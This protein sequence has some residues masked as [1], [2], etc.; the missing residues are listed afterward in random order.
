MKKCLPERPAPQGWL[1]AVLPSF[2]TCAR[3]RV[4]AFKK[5]MTLWLAG[6]CERP[7]AVVIPGRWLQ[8]WVFEAPH[9]FHCKP[10]W[11]VPID[12]SIASPSHL[13][14]DFYSE[15]GSGYPDQ[16]IISFILLGVRYIADLPVQIVL[17]PH[18]KS[19]LPVQATY[20]EE[21]GRF[22]TRGWTMVLDEVPMLPFFI[23]APW[24]LTS[25]GAQMML[26]RLKGIFLMLT[27]FVRSP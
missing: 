1:S 5:K 12:E 9:E 16:E 14:L 24:S 25:Q 26:V 7:Q 22:V 8:C 4:Q 10:G 27:A 17:L 19:F 11:A 13:N 3:D 21:A 23:V 18:P 2:R 15:M 20:L 6:E